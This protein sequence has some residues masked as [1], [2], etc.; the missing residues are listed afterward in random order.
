MRRSE[1]KSC[2]A[3]TKKR[4]LFRGHDLKLHSKP[5]KDKRETLR[6][7]KRKSK[8]S[9]WIVPQPALGGQWSASPGASL[10]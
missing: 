8:E 5:V 3:R 6:H 7:R 9:F 2:R 1:P 10:R 4:E